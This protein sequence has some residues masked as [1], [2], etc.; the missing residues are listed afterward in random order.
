MRRMDEHQ[1]CNVCGCN[2]VCLGCRRRRIRNKKE[3]VFKKFVSEILKDVL[4]LRDS[5]YGTSVTRASAWSD[6][7]GTTELMAMYAKYAKSDAYNVRRFDKKIR[8]MGFKP[9]RA[10]NPKKGK[11]LWEPRPESSHKSVWEGIFKSLLND[12]PG[13]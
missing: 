9:M 1:K 3:A 11:K 2:I 4:V 12:V 6:Y 7:V 5:G 13:G 10:W 8:A